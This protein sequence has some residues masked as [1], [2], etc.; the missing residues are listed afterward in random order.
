[1][2]ERDCSIAEVVCVILGNFERSFCEYCF[3]CMLYGL[4]FYFDPKSDFYICVESVHF[5]VIISKTLIHFDCIKFDIHEYMS[6][7]CEYLTV[8]K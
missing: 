8:D 6:S 1:M 7:D 5:S 2:S 3:N 4:N